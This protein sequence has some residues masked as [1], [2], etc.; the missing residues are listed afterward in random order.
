M[1]VAALI[2]APCISVESAFPSTSGN[3]SNQSVVAAIFKIG[4]TLETW[5]RA[6]AR[7]GF[8]RGKSPGEQPRMG[9]FD[10]ADFFGEIDGV[11]VH[12]RM[13]P[14]ARFA[15]RTVAINAQ[16]TARTR[17]AQPTHEHGST[18]ASAI[19]ADCRIT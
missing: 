15:R 16:F 8:D 18:L 6:T 10:N 14:D 3:R 12:Q 2:S 7:L 13:R 4:F 5:R 1:T 9:S 11:G 17:H 19:A